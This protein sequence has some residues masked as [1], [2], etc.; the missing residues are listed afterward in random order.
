MGRQY[1]APG[2]QALLRNRSR[3]LAVAH[4][5]ER[6]GAGHVDKIDSANLGLGSGGRQQGVEVKAARTGRPPTS[7]TQSGGAHDVPQVAAQ[8]GER[9]NRCLQATPVDGGLREES[10]AAVEIAALEQREPPR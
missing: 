8:V 3:T 9:L 1:T 2:S 10:S 7:P 6:G 5:V 4:E